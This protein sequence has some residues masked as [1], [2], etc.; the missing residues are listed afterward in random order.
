VSWRLNRS[1]I[2]VIS[3]I[4]WGQ[5]SN[6]LS[7]MHGKRLGQDDFGGHRFQLAYMTYAMALAHTH[8]LPEGADHVQSSSTR[9]CHTSVHRS[10]A[11]E[12]Q[13]LG[14]ARLIA[15]TTINAEVSASAETICRSISP[16]P[17]AESMMGKSNA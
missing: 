3:P 10:R 9:A 16:V 7:F 13:D 4:C 6:D 17:P 2:C 5:Q 1:G 15:T 11:S 8:R 12:L 14:R